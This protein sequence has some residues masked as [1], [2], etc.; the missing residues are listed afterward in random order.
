M[1]FVLYVT[2]L[3]DQWENGIRD[4]EDVVREIRTA[5]REEQEIAATESREEP[6]SL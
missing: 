4:P 3:I 6:P 1:S 2:A 5:L